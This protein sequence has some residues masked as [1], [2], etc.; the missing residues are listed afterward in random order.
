MQTK[1][2]HLPY[3]IDPNHRHGFYENYWKQVAL[4]LL[5]RHT[6]AKGR[7]ALDYGCGRGET[8]QYFAAAGFDVTGTDTDPTCVELSAKYGPACVLDPMNPVAQFGEKSF[9]VVACFH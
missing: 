3:E 9:D 1:P 7:T 5:L 8:L 4:K 2:K 6:E